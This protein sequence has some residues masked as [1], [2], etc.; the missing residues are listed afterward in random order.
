MA[1][2][3]C[4]LPVLKVRLLV[5]LSSLCMS[6]GLFMKAARSIPSTFIKENA[7]EKV[8]HVYVPSGDAQHPIIRKEFSSNMTNSSGNQI[9]KAANVSADR[10]AA[11]RGDLAKSSQQPCTQAN[12][13]FDLGFFDGV[14]SV[15]YLQDGYCVLG[16][17]ADPQLVEIAMGQHA[18]W[19]GSGRLT[20]VNVAVAPSEGQTW[21]VFYRNKCTREWNSFYKTI[22]CRTC[23][24]P[25]VISPAACDEVQLV[26]VTC[27]HIIDTFGVPHYMK[28]D[29]EG[30]EPGCFEAFRV[31]GPAFLPQ[32]LSAEIT[33]M[34]YLDTMHSLGYKRFKLVRQDLLHS[35]VASTS[36]PWGDL[37][38]DCRVG[39]VWRTYMEARWELHAILSKGYDANDPCSGGICPVHSQGCAS[40]NMWYDVHAAL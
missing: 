17:E 13:I 9:T 10:S 33:E 2:A 31:L 18:H 27:K 28:M 38:Y 8:L 29:I 22:G 12:T 11:G 19:I 6:C 25:I 15:K 16:V 4:A 30:A 32:F 35:G 34:S 37:A 40:A 26:T 1:R 24:P 3:A 20:M 23:T 39:A 5:F 21:T 7:S 14:D 36:G